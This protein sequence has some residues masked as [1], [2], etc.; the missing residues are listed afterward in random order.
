[1]RVGQRR[2]SIPIGLG[3]SIGRHRKVAG[4]NCEVGSVVRYV[5]IAQLAR[6]AQCGTDRVWTSRNRFTRCAAVGRRDAIRS[7]E[8]SQRACKREIC[9]AVRLARRIRRY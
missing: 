9:V 7:Q 1:M 3:L 8:P 6:G 5:V 4:R 2:I